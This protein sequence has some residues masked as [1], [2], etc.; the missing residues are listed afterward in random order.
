MI[1]AVFS[2]QFRFSPV[3]GDNLGLEGKTVN[4]KRSSGV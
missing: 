4:G 1:V 3:D 2:S